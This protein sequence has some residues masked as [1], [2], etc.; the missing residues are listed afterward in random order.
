MELSVI[1]K[2]FREDNSLTMQEF[3]NMA[4][5]SKGYISMIENGRNPQNKRAL[6]PSIETYSKLA[7]AMGISLD[8]LVLLLDGARVRLNAPS[9]S[10]QKHSDEDLIINA[11]RSADSLTRDMVK[12]CLGISTVDDTDETVNK[13]IRKV[14]RKKDSGI[15]NSA[16]K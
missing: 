4:N 5:L 12:R 16:V 9:S 13:I 8:D 2:K 3:A 10:V 14:S 15:S 6:V 7:G 1:I 11:Y